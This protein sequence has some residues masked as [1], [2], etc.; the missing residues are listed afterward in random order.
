MLKKKTNLICL[1][2]M[3]VTLFV[4]IMSIN[5]IITSQQSSNAL[6]QLTNNQ[7]N[8]TKEYG[9]G[10]QNDNYNEYG[11]SGQNSNSNPFDSNYSQIPDQVVSSTTKI[12][13]NISIE[14]LSLIIISTIIFS[15]AVIY[16]IMSKLSTKNIFIHRDKKIIYVL[17]SSLLSVMILFVSTIVVTN[18]QQ[19]TISPENN[20]QQQKINQQDDSIVNNDTYDFN[21]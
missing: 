16:L 8:D 5:A 6:E 19:N 12:H 2:A 14:A 4:G 7:T 11:Y 13:S 17:A 20:N 15:L 3:I 18:K 10:N 21:I 1:A 9:F